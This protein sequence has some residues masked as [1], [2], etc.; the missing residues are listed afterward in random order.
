[1]RTFSQV[2]PLGYSNLESI[3]M[4]VNIPYPSYD[5]SIFWRACLCLGVLAIFSPHAGA[6]TI[7]DNDF[8]GLSTG[9]L[10]NGADTGSD[11][12]VA[13]SGTSTVSVVDLG[14]GNKALQML[15]NDAGTAVN[16]PG[17][18]KSG[19]TGISTGGS[20]DNQVFG[21]FTMTRLVA[22]GDSVGELQLNIGT[23]FSTGSTTSAAIFRISGTGSVRYW[24]GTTGYIDTGYVL[25]QD[26]PYLVSIAVDL[27]SDVQD[28]WAFTVATAASPGTPVV[29]ISDID[30]RAANIAPTV[31]AFNRSGGSVSAS[32]YMQL[33]NVYFEAS[34]IPELSSTSAL[35]GLVSLFLVLGYRLRHSRRG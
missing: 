22:G 14:S 13:T 1:M 25:A 15:Y 23:A 5:S 30:T 17:L 33:D 27:S 24:S 32:P 18:T 8:N 3:I 28:T 7:I 19:I 29:S 10:A 4:K 20:G 34:A 16:Q 31:I 21:S 35:A 2:G 6:F 26:T 9:T 12:L 11:L